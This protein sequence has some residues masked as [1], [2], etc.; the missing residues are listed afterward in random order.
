[1]ITILLGMT[2]FM[3]VV[4]EAIPSTSEVTPLIS[5]YFS[6][7]M[8]VISLG[9]LCTCICLN[10]EHHHP[11]MEL[12]GWCRYIL[13]DLMGPVLSRSS[14]KRLKR[15]QQE[16]NREIKLSACYLKENQVAPE[17]DKI[18][19]T[20]V[21]QTEIKNE[22]EIKVA[23]MDKVT[24]FIDKSLSEDKRKL[25]WHIVVNIIDN[26]FFVLFLLTITVSS[27]II[28]MPNTDS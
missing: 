20:D 5:T 15:K 9:L 2:V 23:G 19:I 4:V 6:V 13:F 3:I 8:V 10:L 25:E 21:S 12:T 17:E 28:L 26:F 27:L 7:V 24:K 22:K 11:K 1:M 14:V 18:A 16:Y